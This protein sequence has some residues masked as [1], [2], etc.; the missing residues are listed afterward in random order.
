VPAPLAPD[1]TLIHEAPLDAFQEQPP[2]A[3]TATLPLVAPAPTD[4]LDGLSV[5]PLPHGF[6]VVEL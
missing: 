3:L 4:A 5:M 2:A 1:V 6:V